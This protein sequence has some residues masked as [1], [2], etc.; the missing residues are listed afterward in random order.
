LKIVQGKNKG[1]SNT[2]HSK[3]WEDK[4]KEFIYEIFNWVIVPLH[5]AIFGQPPPRISDS[6]ATSLSSVADWYLEVKFLYIRVF[7]TSVPPYALP[8]FLPDKL[9]C[10]EIARQSVLSGIRKELKGVLK[11]VWSP[12][13]ICIDAF[14]LLDFGHAKVEAVALEEM[15][16]VDIEFKKHDPSK[17]VRNHL[18]SFGLKRY[19]HEDSPHDEI[20]WGARS[21]M[22]VLSQIQALPPGDMTEFFKFWEHRQSCL[23]QIL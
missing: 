19:E 11:K 12:F 20:F 2:Y 16:L 3:I 14:S 6:V 17:V 7:E 13:P 4:A 23:P 15:K 21:F 22:K 9:L 5:V 1:G 10:C 18:T 8:L